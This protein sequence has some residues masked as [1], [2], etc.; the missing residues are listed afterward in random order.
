MTRPT[1][2]SDPI[3]ENHVDET[4]NDLPLIEDI[5]TI[6]EERS[7]ELREEEEEAEAAAAAAAAA[8][9]LEAAAKRSTSNIPVISTENDKQE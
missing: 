3:L 5:T 7:E 4:E 9:V 1:D 8:A 2:N 6:P